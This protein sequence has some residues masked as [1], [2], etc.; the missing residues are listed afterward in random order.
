[1]ATAGAIIKLQTDIE[2]IKYRVKELE[3]RCTDIENE[4]NF[5]KKIMAKETKKY[6]KVYLKKSIVI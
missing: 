5:L 1:M 3:C 6:M 2:N 4:L